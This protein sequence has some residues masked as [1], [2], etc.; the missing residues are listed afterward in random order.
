MST[1]LENHFAMK[2]NI[3]AAVFALLVLGSC[4]KDKAMMDAVSEYNLAKETEG[5]HF[6]DEIKLPREIMDDVESVSISFGDKETSVLTV[7]PQFFTL[8]D[9]AVVMNIRTKSGENLA[10]DAIINV[11]A[12]TP[13]QN[14]TYQVVSEYPHNSENFVQG[15]EL[16]G[17]TIYG[18]NGQYGHSKV[19]KYPL[20]SVQN[21]AETKLPDDFF[22]EGSTIIGDKLYQLTWQQKKGIIYN[23]ATLEK[24]GEFLYP[25]RIAEGWGIT[26]DWQHIIVS[27][28]SKNIYFLDPKNTQNIVRT[29]AVAG[30]KEVYDKINELE[31]H[32]GFIYANLWQSP[33]IL[34]INPKNGEVV[35]KMD[36]SLIAQKHTQGAD[37][38]LNGIA[39]KG[40]HMLITGKLWNKIY[41]IQLN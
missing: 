16:E 38:V 12:K 7:D 6:G 1:F 24:V 34:K 26:Y 14:L 4:N 33:Y 35:A 39:F 18:S 41:E 13:E 5:Y 11:Y 28:G 25:N 19:I 10:V 40:E 9:N 37:D 23:K 3:F 8:G 36:F 20:G 2:K 32:D 29:I 30:G 27:D 22:G 31:Y 17:N 21:V 15:F